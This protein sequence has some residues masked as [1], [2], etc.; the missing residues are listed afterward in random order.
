[1]NAFRARRREAMAE[2]LR[3]LRT[4]LP[5]MNRWIDELLAAHEP[6]ST[7]VSQ[8][9]YQGLSACFPA[10]LLDATR[11]VIAESVPFPPVS[12]LGLSEL[13]AMAGSRMAGI[14]FR[15]MYFLCGPL[16][17]EQ[18]HFHELVHVIQW[19]ALGSDDFLLTYGASLLLHGYA[20]NPL[21]AVAFDLEARFKRG[22]RPPGVL[23]LVT[24]EALQ[25]RHAAVAAFRACGL[26]FGA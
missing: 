11:V 9:G 6:G 5:A 19:R 25:A 10:S 2:R 26:D 14:T 4:A 22:A 21:E 16:P 20:R 18:V 3:R 15:A 8:L 7:P 1:M 17:S 23:E 12:A 13:D 24:G